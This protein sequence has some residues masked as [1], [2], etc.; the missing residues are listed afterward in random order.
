VS[1]LAEHVQAQLRSTFEG[2]DLV[3][4]GEVA[5]GTTRAVEAWQRFGIGRI[6]VLAGGPGTG[7]QPDELGAEL[8]IY[9]PGPATNM[10]E[11]IRNEERICADP[12]PATR[13]V[14]E[15]F[16]PERQALLLAPM[17]FAVQQFGDRALFGARR[18]EWIA[19]EDKTRNDELFDDVG[20][21]HPPHRLL[22]TDPAAVQEAARALDT[23]NG[24]VWSGDARDGFNGGGVFVRWVRDESDAEEALAFL[25]PRCDTLRIAPF[26]EG[27]PCSVHGFV[28]G[29]GVAVFR[30][31]ELLT[32]RTEARPHLRYC[33]CATYFDPPAADLDAMRAAVRRLGEALRAAV[34]FRG[35][36]TVDGILGAYGWV[37]TECNPRFGVGLGYAYDLMPELPL[38]ALNYAIIAGAA[39]VPAAELEA[40]VMN[41]AT[42][43]RWGG[44]WTQV[45]RPVAD[46][47]TE[48][49]PEGT[50][51]L[52]PGATG[53]FVRCMFDERATPVGPSV[54]GRAAAV[55]ARAEAEYELGLP[56]L[57]PARAVR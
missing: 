39:D 32:L 47:F 3:L 13:A 36:F 42:D 15:R 31:V 8:H 49:V 51:S 6:L 53:G 27:I 28:T 40:V 25:A 10:I 24:T 12:P 48:T 2:R 50:L 41:V 18:P 44:V 38:P 22:S 35:A 9:D 11:G 14:L 29:D 45:P 16:D 1:D 37:A 57:E 5:A 33:G 43:R 23:G 52:G 55:L 34:A 21:P 26:V 19:L 20:L 17:Y 4:V 46:T 7:R 30:A 54:A 56:P